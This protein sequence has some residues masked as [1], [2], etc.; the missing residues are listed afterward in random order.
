MTP[1]APASPPKILI[2][3]DHPATRRLLEEVLGQEY[4]VVL[5]RTGE[6]ALSRLKACPDID[7]VLLDVVMP[8]I[9]GYQVC[10][11]IR[12]DA[13]TR[14]L[15]VVFLTVLDEAHDEARGFEAGVTD[16]IVKPISRLRLLARVRNQLAVRQ[17][18]RELELRNLE[19]MQALDQIKTL[20]GILPICSFCKQIRNDQGAWQLLEE[21]I[22]SHSDT[23]FSHSVCP[24]CAKE[25]YPELF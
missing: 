18:Q 7:L 15:P 14:D 2:V 24:K 5:A 23:Q 1:A 19:L 11:A 9:N 10:Q 13:A 16:Y 4:A 17:K 6:E 22:Q 8:G 12:Q 3:D 25:H 20:H 21:Y